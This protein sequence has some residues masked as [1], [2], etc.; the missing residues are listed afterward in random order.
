MRRRK[1]QRKPK[2]RFRFKRMQKVILVF[3]ALVLVL[4]IAQRNVTYTKQE[5]I[6]SLLEE[7]AFTAP[8]G[9]QEAEC[10]LVSDGS[11]NGT[12]GAEMMGEILD[13]MRVPWEG[14]QVEEFAGKDLD[15]YEKLVFSADYLGP[16]SDSLL[17]VIDWVKDGGSLM[18]LYPPED[19]WGF[20]SLY[21][22]LGIARLDGE[23]A[24]VEQIHFTEN[25]MMGG[26]G[27]EYGITD[28]YESSLN[29]T[30]TA[31][32]RVYL[33][34]GGEASAPLLW[35]REAGEGIVVVDNLNFL[36]KAYRGF[37]SAAYTLLD[38]AEAW[39]VINGSTFYI[40]DFPSPVP[41]GDGGRIREDYDMDI[42]DFYTQI[43][44][45]D[46]YNLGEQYGIRYTGLVIEQYSDQVEAPFERNMDTQR[47]EYFGN[48][49]LDA[50][51]ELGFHGYN[52]MPL[53]LNNFSYQGMF[54]SYRQ[55]ASYEDMRAGLQEL[56]DFCRE[57]FPEEEFAVYVPP[58]NILSEEG[59]QMLA[60][61]FPQIRAVAS[62]YLP[63][64]LAFEQE[65]EV[66]E[67]GIIDTPRVISGYILDDYMRLAAVSELNF[68]FVNSHFQHP[69]DV[70][71]VDR[72]ADLGWEELYRRISDYT[73]WLYT[74]APSIRN[75]TG[76]ELA[77][78]VQQ[79]DYLDVK[80]TLTDTA[81]ELELGG[82]G[83]EAWL[84]VRV[85]EGTPGSV[86]G[87]ELTQMAEGLYLLRADEA[88]VVIELQK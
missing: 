88:H 12:K 51:G 69:D 59:R 49:L 18:L 26:E 41:G 85:N 57:V 30:L 39:P 3:L 66:A 87:G 22:L 83:T 62:V 84:M 82:F 64:S 17:S 24:Y 20:R 74:S 38:K 5:R 81:L 70:L 25:F 48:L 54:D 86:T 35:R 75:L 21:S 78:A 58:S 55:W 73:E 65:F 34:S 2:E 14:C 33:D 61:D 4:C 60:R 40:D 15:S 9:E 52:H 31:D 37:H 7:E 80:R 27:K 1:K 36:D 72:G 43:W 10:L 28:A 56:N 32:C 11:D 8:L 50:G 47:Y 13:Q 16:L 63:G 19:D 79:Y 6:L 67:D 76:S 46:I 71:D 42:A 53:C 23:R 29:V 77:A 44:W 68:H 45:P